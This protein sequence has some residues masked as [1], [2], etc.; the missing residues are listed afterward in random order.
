MNTPHGV[1]MKAAITADK[2]LE[3]EAFGNRGCS[4]RCFI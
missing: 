2:A 1:V 3:G 4:N